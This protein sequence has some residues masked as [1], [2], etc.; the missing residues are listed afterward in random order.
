MA[1]L[2]LV[3]PNSVGARPLT[4]ERASRG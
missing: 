2:H 4:T 1:F 3:H